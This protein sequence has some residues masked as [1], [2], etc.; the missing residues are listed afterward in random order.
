MLVLCD[1]SHRKLIH[2]SN[3]QK[4]SEKNCRIPLRMQHPWVDHPNVPLLLP[5]VPSA[6]RH[7]GFRKW[8]CCSHPY[9][10]QGTPE[11][12]LVCR[13]GCWPP[14]STRLKSY[15]ESALC[16]GAENPVAKSRD[17][18]A[19]SH[20]RPGEPGEGRGEGQSTKE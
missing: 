11:C 6:M 10:C 4:S 18:F 9:G 2:P 3:D 12:R 14:P 8:E 5:Q 20:S 7:L 17:G 13:M 15:L 1:S 16:Q 19:T